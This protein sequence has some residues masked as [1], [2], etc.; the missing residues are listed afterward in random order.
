MFTDSCILEIVHIELLIKLHNIKIMGV[1][2]LKICLTHACLHSTVS[3]I[4]MASR[5]SE[6]FE[7]LGLKYKYVACRLNTLVREF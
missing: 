5:P 6:W 4:E 1:I 3:I 7:I 2:E